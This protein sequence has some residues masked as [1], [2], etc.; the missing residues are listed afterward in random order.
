MRLST[1]NGW[2]VPLGFRLAVTIEERFKGDQEGETGVSIIPE[3]QFQ[4]RRTGL[5]SPIRERA[6]RRS[7]RNRINKADSQFTIV[8]PEVPL[9]MLKDVLEDLS[10][11]YRSSMHWMDEVR[12]K[13]LNA[14]PEL[15]TSKGEPKVI[16]ITAGQTQE[17][18][19]A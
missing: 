8:G 3:W 4:F 12:L 15:L 17:E 9:F 14:N 1:V 11:N 19:H 7:L 5:L 18:P 6:Y 16:S 2:L 10:E 13:H